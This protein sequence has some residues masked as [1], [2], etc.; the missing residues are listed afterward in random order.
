MTRPTPDAQLH[1]YVIPS[2]P[3]GRWLVVYPLPGM[4]RWAAPVADCRTWLQA[5]AEADRL[6]NAAASLTT[7]VTTQATTHPSCK[8]HF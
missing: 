5:L 2:T 4:D 6:N 7:H 3:P 8:T 1:H